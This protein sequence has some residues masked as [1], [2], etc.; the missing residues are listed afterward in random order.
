MSLVVAVPPESMTLNLFSR[1]SAVMELKFSEDQ[2]FCMTLLYVAFTDIENMI[3]D[4]VAACS[5]T[6]NMEPPFQL[7]VAAFTGSEHLYEDALL[8]QRIPC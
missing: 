5:L 6:R 4:A 1:I 7:R 2:G 3:G 8:I